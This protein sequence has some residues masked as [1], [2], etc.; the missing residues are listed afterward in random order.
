MPQT[1]LNAPRIGGTYLLTWT[2]YGTW[3]PGDTRGFVSIIP[4]SRGG[5]VIHNEPGQAYDSDVPVLRATARQR[6]AGPVVR[7][8]SQHA[9]I[10]E[11]A[12][13]EVADRHRV[14]I[15]AC[16]IMTDHVHI[17]AECDNS[18]G[19]RLLNL[20]KGV[21]S[22]RLGERFGPRASGRWWT[23]HG[24]RRLLPNRDAIAAAERYVWD[25]PG[26]IATFSHAPALSPPR[27]A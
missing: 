13:R 7:I 1:S 10:V 8:T 21:S 14:G 16:A 23:E 17:V 5:Y 26:A 11:S 18:D 9:V 20:F 4:D 2:T 22:R 12:F 27:P 6:Q 3:L 19:A 25:Q 15:Y 24:S